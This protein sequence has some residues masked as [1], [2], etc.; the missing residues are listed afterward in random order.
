MSFRLLGTTTARLLRSTTAAAT[1]TRN[2]TASPSA[3]STTAAL[4]VGSSNSVGGSSLLTVDQA[5]RGEG[6]IGIGIGSVAATLVLLSAASTA[7][8]N[9]LLSSSSDEEGGGKDDNDKVVETKTTNIIFV[10][11]QQKNYNSDSRSN[12]FFFPRLSLLKN[13]M[14]HM[15][16]SVNTTTTMCEAAP[17][18]NNSII[19]DDETMKELKKER[20]D[21]QR[22]NNNK[23][24]NIRNKNRRRMT[25]VG[26]FSLVSETS[27]N[28][29][30]P[31]L[32][33]AMT[34][35]PWKSDDFRRLYQQR[36]V[37]EKHPRF[38][39]RL[40]STKTH[41]VFDNSD[42]NDDTTDVNETNND[43]GNDNGI[44]YYGGRA[45]VAKKDNVRE[46]LFP[47][48]PIAE[49]KDRINDA[50]LYEPL[51]LNI[52]LWEAWTATGGKFGQSGAITSQ[53]IQ[54]GGEDENDVESLLL[55]RAHHCMADGVSLGALFGDLMD[56]GPEIQEEIK[57][58]IQIFRQKKK[59]TP[60][61]K[62]LLF[63]LYYWIWG[64][65]KALMYQVYL[66]SISWYEGW[67]SPH[68]DPWVVL[69]TIY[70][71][72]RQQQQGSSQQQQQH[73]PRSLSWATVAPVDEVK[74]VAEFYSRQ[75]Q[76][77][78][79]NGGGKGRSSRIT[80]N[81]V[82][83]SCVS[84]AI[85][86]QLQYHRS[87]NPQLSSSTASNKQLSLPYMNLIIP[88][89]LQGGILLPGKIVQY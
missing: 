44:V 26:R 71:E 82:F 54:K 30:V 57:R 38:S 63:G 60:W 50:A 58:Q 27:R 72:K 85:I 68:D 52:R 37:S 64:T 5:R 86:K 76:Q 31:V 84:A 56:E 28:P 78:Q 83:C 6:G 70:D 18:K 51:D 46:L 59:K 20:R 13:W 19:N 62:K 45:S 2:A 21:Q 67:I 7:S 39:A 11:Q 24:N 9:L 33:L 79:E 75:Q 1:T 17:T 15:A 87:V 25:N 65:I 55:F 34:G 53:K 80:I 48:I 35:K 74:K 49:L 61:W 41:F 43:N 23:I 42:D 12:N 32:V 69:S 73:P 81:D 4:A 14:H 16:S 29:S 77:Q 22:N 10:K 3:S 40:D 8:W 88:V 47:A 66:F 89:H 36:K